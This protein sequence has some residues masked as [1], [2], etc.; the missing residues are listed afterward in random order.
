MKHRKVL[1]IVFTIAVGFAMAAAT[2]L[3]ESPGMK[4][5]Q[6]GKGWGWVWG[7]KDEVGALNE[8]T[9]ASRLGALRLADQGKVYDLGIVYD[10]TSYKWPG[11]SPAEV[12]MFRSPE[13]VKRQEDIPG[14]I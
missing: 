14:V 2:V 7:A 3:T 5:W 4:K 11:H 6:K 12:M 9:D 10:R 13:G 8:M 1:L